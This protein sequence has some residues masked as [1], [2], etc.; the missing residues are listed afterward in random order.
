MKFSVTLLWISLVA[1]SAAA[2]KFAVVR[3]TDIYRELASTA[4]MQKDLKLQRDAIL[5]N[6]RAVQLRGII[7]E[8]HVLQSQFQAKKNEMESE[9]GKKLVRDFEIKRQEAETLRQEFE[10]FRESEDKRINKV[11][12]ETMRSSLDRIS[13]AAQQIAKERN[14]EG[15]F[16]VSGNSNTGLPFI[17]YTADSADLTEDVIEFLAEKPLDEAE[18]TQETAEEAEPPAETGDKPEE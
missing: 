9:S 1:I 18:E 6:K 12:V 17:L 5:Q 2:P 15:V 16:D 3:V 10:D 14:L 7:G 4:E 11:M 8:L 13:G